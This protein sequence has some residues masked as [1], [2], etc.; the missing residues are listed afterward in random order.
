MR[1]P[2]ETARAS[3]AARLVSRL[4][5]AAASA[6]A[7]DVRVG[8]GYT[9][10]L[11]DDGRAGLAFTFR[12]LA[13]GGCSALEGSAPLC[14]RP[15]ADLLALLESGDT[16]EAS[17]GLACANAL[18]NRDRPDQLAGD[19]LDRLA[20][21]PDD[22]VGMVGHFGPLVEPILGK[23]RSLTVFERVDRPTSLIRPPEDAEEELPHCEV[24]LIT[25]TSI[26]NHTVDGLLH[27]ARGC[28]EVVLL[29]A[30][31]P[32]LPEVF[33]AGEV[34]LLSGVVVRDPPE[35]LRVVSEA[36]GMRQFGPH[37][38]KVTVRAGGSRGPT[39]SSPRAGARRGT[40]SS[41]SR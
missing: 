12:D 19:V 35:V 10:V 27:A 26:I 17:L 3:V 34:T 18:A 24:A 40:S 4:L 29:G 33:A 32:L 16:I 25:A 21:R 7:A 2:D 23:A 41:S 8:L 22:R 39:M 38:R 36:R 30:S 9:A 20:L 14:G 6:R 15:A 37:V 1:P 5:D 11:L 31:T 13:P 28:R